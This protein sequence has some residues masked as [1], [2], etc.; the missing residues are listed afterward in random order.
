[1]AELKQRDG[2]ERRGKEGRSSRCDVV[3]PLVPFEDV[4]EV[5]LPSGISGFSF[6]DCRERR[7][8]R[9]GRRAKKN[10]RGVGSR[11]L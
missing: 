7:R 6:W 4:V 9:E 2:D 10:E 5:L 11:Q 1:M 3:L 8:G